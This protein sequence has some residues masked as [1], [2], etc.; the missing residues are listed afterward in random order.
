MAAR[1][2]KTPF[3]ATGDK[4][5][6]A[7]ADQPDGKV[8][9]QAGWTPDYE[10]PNDNANYRPVGRAEM[11]GI[12][13]EVTEGL[14]DVQ[15]NGFATWQ[16]VDGGWPAGAFVSHGGDVF[17][18]SATANVTIPGAPGAF[19]DP[20]FRGEMSQYG[21][22]GL[23]AQNNASTPNTQFDIAADMVAL[24]DPSTGATK[25]FSPVES[26]TANLLTA[27]PVVNGRDQAAAFPASSWIHFYLISNGSAVA[28]IASLAVPPTGPA[29]PAGYT[30]WAYV[31]AV[32]L[33]SGSA[34]SDVR[35]CG[36]TVFYRV[37]TIVLTGTAT[38]NTPFSTGNLVPPN[39]L[40]WAPMVEN[41]ALSASGAGA[42]ALTLFIDS[43]QV[44]LSGTGNASAAYSVS[45]GLAW[46]PNNGQSA[47]YRLNLMSG[48]GPTT[49]ISVYGYRLS[50][51]G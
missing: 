42:Y 22:R 34:L 14:G 30:M 12:I 38:T 39:A 15:L 10:L 23:R 17:R 4:E 31:G 20:A 36:D 45:G 1:I 33:S 43:Y 37:P 7:T 13:G 44:G 24:R 29:M 18:S 8:S 35:V 6:L 40:E 19:W 51:G 41:L 3:A 2:Y 48:S 47:Q 27:G 9:L 26:V 50:N 25:V 32:R 46:L 16:A 5:A 49:T 11:N 28:S 21:T